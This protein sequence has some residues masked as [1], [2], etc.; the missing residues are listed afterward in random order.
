[1]GGPPS[2]IE[3]EATSVYQMPA[4]RDRSFSDPRDSTIMIR[5]R[6]PAYG[7]A[8]AE[9]R[10]RGLAPTRALIVDRDFRNTAA[11][12]WR[13][14]VP[15]NEDPRHFDLSICRG[16]SPLLVCTGADFGN[17]AL[18]HEL[19][20]AGCAVDVVI[21]DNRFSRWIEPNGER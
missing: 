6:L 2:N 12:P 1:M 13:V 17:D 9:L 14:V 10:R 3:E 21:Q 8:I 4:L 20:Q 16:L 18:I 15:A 19:R 7:R 11:H 5:R